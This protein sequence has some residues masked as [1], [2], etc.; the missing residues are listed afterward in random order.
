[1]QDSITFISGESII[2]LVC[3][4]GY[5]LALQILLQFNGSQV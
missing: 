5:P 1:M 3:E 2:G 4:E